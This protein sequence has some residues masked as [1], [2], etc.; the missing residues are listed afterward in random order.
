MTRPRA[1]QQP[2]FSRPVEVAE[3][4]AEGLRLEIVAVAAERA[5]LARRFGLVGLD[6]LTAAA[7]IAPVSR[8]LFRVEARFEAEAIQTCVVTLDPVPARL[9]VSFSA[10]F[11]EGGPGLRALLA[12]GEDEDEPEPIEGGAIDLGETVAQ[13]LV[14]SLDP[15]PRKPGASLPPQDAPDEAAGKPFAGLEALK[16]RR[17]R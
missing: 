17:E 4:G 2:E 8:T 3:V 16:T 12:S 11:G 13:H 1:A 15:Y 9:S 10:L 14:L 5:A 6:R 7:T